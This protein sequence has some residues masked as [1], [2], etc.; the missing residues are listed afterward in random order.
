MTVALKELVDMED[1]YVGDGLV[2]P[3]SEG[4]AIP[5]KM[6]ED[7]QAVRG[8][9]VDE[10]KGLLAEAFGITVKALIRMAA[11]V[12]RLEELGADLVGLRLALVQALR[13]IAYG[14]AVPEAVMRSLGN[15]DAMNRILSL[16]IPEQIKVANDGN[17]EVAELAESGPTFRLVPIP[18]LSKQQS[19][20]VFA[21]DH[22]RTVPE[23]INIL[24]KPVAVRGHQEPVVFDKKRKCIIVSGDRIHITAI[25]LNDYL[26][27]L[28]E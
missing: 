23:Q 28:M 26:R 3:E 4:V 9:T 2:D 19:R 25:Q 24:R 14:Q 11:I 21:R 8:C 18:H 27:R 6:L 7:Y 16:P 22:V 10:L 5:A 20:M 15:E 1:D 17:V 12:R 13:K